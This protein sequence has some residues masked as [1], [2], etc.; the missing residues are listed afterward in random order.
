[1]TE[2]HR[3]RVRA[4]L[5]VVLAIAQPAMALRPY[6]PASRAITEPG[7]HMPVPGHRTDTDKQGPS[8]GGT[9]CTICCCIPSTVLGSALVDAKVLFLPIQGYASPEVRVRE[10][11]R[12][13][14]PHL[15]PFAIAPP[16]TA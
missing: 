6:I 15:L 10:R 3:T 5:A 14:P 1:M 2:Q 8:R 12:H 11:P 7:C 16:V 9:P 13:P 4:A